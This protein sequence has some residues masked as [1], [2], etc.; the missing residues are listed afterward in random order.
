MTELLPCPFCTSKAVEIEEI[1][2]GDGTAES[3]QVECPACLARGPEHTTVDQATRAW[4]E[5]DGIAPA[6]GCSRSE[7]AAWQ[8]KAK[9]HDDTWLHIPDCFVDEYRADGWDV[10]P[11]Y[12]A[13]WHAQHA[14]DCALHNAPA[15]PVGPCDCGASSFESGQRAEPKFYGAQCPSYPNCSGGCGLGC[16]HEFESQAERRSE[17]KERTGLDVEE[18]QTLDG[19]EAFIEFG[20]GWAKV[21]YRREVTEQDRASL[22]A[23][24]SGQNSGQTDALA[25]IAEIASNP[26]DGPEAMAQIY[27]IVRDA[28]SSHSPGGGGHD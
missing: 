20:T 11:L 8:V 15:L 28:S 13:P 3:A 16:S 12:A 4:N 24:V 9:G 22:A 17:R 23:A 21:H 27:A 2:L 5:R 25:K 19:S 6:Q 14:S 7:P 26:N 1:V 10:R 18:A